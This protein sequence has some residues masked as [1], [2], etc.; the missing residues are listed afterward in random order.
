MIAAAR[1]PVQSQR[2]RTM[3]KWLKSKDF[4]KFSVA[5][6]IATITLNRPE[7]RNALSPP[8]LRELHEALLEA[9]DLVEVSV[10]VIEGEGQDF[11][12][13]YDLAFG[14]DPANQQ[15]DSGKYRTRMG[16]FDDDCWT[17]ERK[18]GQMLI[19]PD[20]HKPVIAKVHGRCL[21]GGA[22]LALMCDIVIAAEDAKIGHPGTR[23]LGAPP[24]NMWFYH[25]GPQW[26]KRLLLTGDSISG[27]DAAQI[28]LVLDAVPADELAAEVDALA[29]RMTLIDADMLACQKRVV[30]LAMELT[31]SRNMQRISMEMD[32]RAHFSSGPRRAKLKADLKELGVRTAVRKRDS[33]FGD[34]MVHIRTRRHKA[35]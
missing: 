14:S 10:I 4:I 17:M 33:L 8:L 2:K 18:M 12:S 25:V 19:I 27:L 34:G 9:D 28:G 1:R 3:S 35:G 7:K 22:E 15:D 30:N 11:C 29:R 21:A 6:Q 13:G 5:D 16:N 23:S 26:A 24:V 20:I 31:G 32:A